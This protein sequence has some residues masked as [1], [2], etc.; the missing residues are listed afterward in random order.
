MSDILW[1]GKGKR[2]EKARKKEKK[3]NGLLDRNLKIIET[4][5]IK[6]QLGACVWVFYIQL[7]Y[8]SAK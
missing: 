1:F 6:T 8:T 7:S 4:P 2:P 3:K 5:F